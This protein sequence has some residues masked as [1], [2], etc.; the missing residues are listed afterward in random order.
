MPTMLLA[1]FPYRS[2]NIP[3]V[4]MVNRNSFPDF[5][6]T[7][8]KI[9]YVYPHSLNLKKESVLKHKVFTYWD[10][11]RQLGVD[12]SIVVLADECLL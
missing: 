2:G 11:S 12:D 9:P 10:N 4:P 1:E 7:T 6:D 3:S 8:H 5:L